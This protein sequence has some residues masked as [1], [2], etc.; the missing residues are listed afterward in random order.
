MPHEMRSNKELAR[1]DLWA[2]TSTCGMA[3]IFAKQ[4]IAPYAHYIP[5]RAVGET[6]AFG[7]V[8][9]DLRHDG[10]LPIF[11]QLFDRA[12]HMTGKNIF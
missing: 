8:V 11:N 4:P 12:G 3:P 2:R 5:L 10:W 1:P 9:F 6:C 7:C